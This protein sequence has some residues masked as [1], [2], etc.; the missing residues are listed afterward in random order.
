MWHTWGVFLVL[1]ILT[2]IFTLVTIPRS[3]ANFERAPWSAAIVVIN[4]LAVANIPRAIYAGKPFQAFLSSAVTICALVFLFS[5]ALWPNIVTASN[6]PANSLTIYRAASSEKTLRI[7][8]L[9]AMIGMPFVLTYP[10][11]IYWT[12]R[13]RVD[14]G[15]GGY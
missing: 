6:D 7:A 1:Y 11:I 3:T 4:V 2:T 15:E 9:I 13:G 8:F 12:F 14:V 5:M 10:A